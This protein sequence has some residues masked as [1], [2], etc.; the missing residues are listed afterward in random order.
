MGPGVWWTPLMSV[1]S[2]SNW[3]IRAVTPIEPLREPSIMAIH[4][5]VQIACIITVGCGT[6]SMKSKAHFWD[7]GRVSSTV[8]RLVGLAM[9]GRLP[10][11]SCKIGVVG[12]KWRITACD[13]FW[14]K[15][16]V[17]PAKF[18]VAIPVR[19]VKSR[20]CGEPGLEVPRYPSCTTDGHCTYA[21]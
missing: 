19:L 13:K 5:W 11:G 9:V 18:N 2:W 20:G 8:W 3:S 10:G 6:V 16:V 15:S 17:C 14:E 4:W 21:Q 7:A 12:L 1:W